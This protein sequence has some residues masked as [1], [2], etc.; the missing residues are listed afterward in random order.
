ME[1]KYRRWE[2]NE[3]RKGP[4][5]RAVRPEEIGLEGAMMN[6]NERRSVEKCHEKLDE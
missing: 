6:R 2:K 3:P 4:A 1:K 5:R